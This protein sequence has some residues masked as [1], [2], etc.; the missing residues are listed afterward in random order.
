MVSVKE[1]NP[2]L[3][4]AEIGKPKT[5]THDLPSDTFTYGAATRKMDYGVGKLTS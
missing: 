1:K 2:I 4:K 3:A 5:F